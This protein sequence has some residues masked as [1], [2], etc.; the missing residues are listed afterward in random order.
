MFADSQASLAARRELRRQEKA[1]RKTE[2]AA[3][4]LRKK[5]AKQ[6]KKQHKKLSKPEKSANLDSDLL[7][8]A[9]PFGGERAASA[10]HLAANEPADLGNSR[11]QLTGHGRHVRNDGEDGFI[12]TDPVSL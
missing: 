1:T 9:S 11:S 7:S 12:S 8:S 4:K 3:K 6:N 10:R 2:R 5:Q